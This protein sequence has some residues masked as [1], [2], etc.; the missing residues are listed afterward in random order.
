M[1]SERR[2]L[3]KEKE[4]GVEEEGWTVR[5]GCWWVRGPDTTSLWYALRRR[6]VGI[7][8]Q[9]PE[10]PPDGRVERWGRA[11]PE[12][13]P[14]LKG[15]RTGKYTE[16]V[17]CHWKGGTREVGWDTLRT[18]RGSGDLRQKGPVVTT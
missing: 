15:R 4:G 14:D 10:G 2:G 3:T 17:E 5:I 13:E 16:G 1:G 9:G 11:E 7:E 6:G 8:L 18:E 12:R